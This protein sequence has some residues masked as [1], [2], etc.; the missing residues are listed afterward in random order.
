M[1]PARAACGT[2]RGESTLASGAL[3][4]VDGYNVLRVSFS[5]RQGASAPWW[6]ADRRTALVEHASRQAGPEDAVWIVFDARH[7]EGADQEDEAI[8]SPAVRTIFTRSADDWIL[9]AARDEAGRWE[10]IWVVTADRQLGDRATSRGA[11]RM[12]TA[13]FVSRF[14]EVPG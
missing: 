9:R 3:W 4:L 13:D 7:L 11:R 5:G 1:Q 14:T 8:G 6:G 2:T 10:T 12:S